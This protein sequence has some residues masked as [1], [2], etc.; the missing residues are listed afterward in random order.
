M[1]SSFTWITSAGKQTGRSMTNQAGQ[2][3]GSKVVLVRKR[4]A[5]KICSRV[6]IGVHAS[7][8]HLC[9]PVSTHV[10]FLSEGFMTFCVLT[11]GTLKHNLWATRGNSS[12]WRRSCCSYIWNSTTSLWK[13][14]SSM[15]LSSLRS[16]CFW[17]VISFFS[18]LLGY[19]LSI[20][21]APCN[22]FRTRIHAV[23]YLLFCINGVSFALFL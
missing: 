13:W 15:S 14:H 23:A 1:L 3:L 5:H 12:C 16:T 11:S 10:L 17:L 4:V 20:V 2:F 9:E 21:F 8:C 22:V 19:F 18:K 6:I 7:C